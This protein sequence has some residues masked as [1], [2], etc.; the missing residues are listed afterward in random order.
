MEK[1]SGNSEIPESKKNIKE[2][3]IN[4]DI[5]SFF[6][7]AD[8][9]VL[10]TTNKRIIQVIQPYIGEI[11][12][13]NYKLRERKIENYKHKFEPS[14]DSDAKEE[15][16]QCKDLSN[17][18]VDSN[19]NFSMD[20][21]ENSMRNKKRKREKESKISK[22]HKKKQ[23]SS[24]N[25]DSHEDI[26]SDMSRQEKDEN[27]S[28]FDYIEL[29]GLKNYHKIKFEVNST[30][31]ESEA[32]MK[33][34]LKEFYINEQ[35]ITVQKSNYPNY[36]VPISADIRNFK[37]LNLA[38]KQ[39]ELT[40]K[41]FDVIMMDPPWQLSSSQPTRGVAIAYDT[42][43]DNI[44]ENIPVEK[45]QTDG[46]IFIWTINAKFKVTLDLLKQWGYK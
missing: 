35:S 17:S 46:F 7:K 25:E 8:G 42:L 2:K 41:L 20:H 12:D 39:M 27:D 38:D 28:D 33:K 26:S 9:P 36:C 30:I 1:E 45:L 4:K 43:N 22:K 21:S 3:Q 13:R 44:I 14:D 19:E 40:G 29:R 16:V 11:N 24:E 5:R 34:L 6:P 18:L 23:K 10:L 15:E 31:N 32:E 37:F